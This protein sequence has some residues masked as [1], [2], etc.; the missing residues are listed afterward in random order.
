MTLVVVMSYM[1][2]KIIVP[3]LVVIPCLPEIVASP[4]HILICFAGGYVCSIH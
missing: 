4:Y 2:G 3:A 1:L